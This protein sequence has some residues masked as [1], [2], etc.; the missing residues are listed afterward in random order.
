MH[1][2][3]LSTDANHSWRTRR[4]ARDQGVPSVAGCTLQTV[5]IGDNRGKARPVVMSSPMPPF[6]QAGYADQLDPRWNMEQLMRSPDF[7]TVRNEMG[8][9]S[10]PQPF[11]GRLAIVGVHGAL[12]LSGPIT[13]PSAWRSPAQ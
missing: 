9:V 10:P 5:G 1:R 12:V 8:C 3:V 2:N 13:S 6:R 7:S 11:A 4:I